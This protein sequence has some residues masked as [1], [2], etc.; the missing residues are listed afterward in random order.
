MKF[1]VNR[2][3]F[4]NNLNSVL[5]ATSSRSTIP[6][7]EG[8]K[9]VLTDEG[10][11]MT[12]SNTD[13]SIEL[14]V[15]A[16]DDLQI[17]STGEI[18]VR[19][20][21]FSDI[22]RKLPGKDFTF[23]VQEGNQIKITSEHA[24]YM[25]NGLDPSAYPRLPE[26]SDDQSFAI[27]AKTLR[28]LITQ[29][30]FAVATDN[31]RPTLTGVSFTFSQKQIKAVATDSHRLSQRVVGV[32]NGPSED[33]SLIIPGKNL[34]ELAQLIADADENLKVFLGDSQ[35]R[36]DFDNLSFYTRLL[37]GAYPNVDRLL[38]ATSSTSVQFH[39]SDLLSALSRA[40]LVTHVNRT[41]A[42]QM[43]IDAENNRVNLT[44]NSPDL[45][46]V[47]ETVENLGIEGKSLTISFN[48]DYMSAALR[49]SVTDIVVINFTEAL[50]PFTVVPNDNEID[51]IQLITPIRTF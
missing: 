39:V 18:V 30:V 29:T 23:D 19:A 17:A 37:E 21:L 36:F 35:V 16:S 3:Y 50:R 6:I 15:K 22:V 45:G 25:I 24:E 51:F 49:A 2:S 12:G 9:M 46:K 44:G 33:L 28:E 48:P 40:S 26:I 4:I 34:Q 1:T 42:V 5:K 43:E 38:P 32:D 13:I 20:H 27:S 47:E 31:S 10:L 7:L 8:I 11:V 14:L 41:N